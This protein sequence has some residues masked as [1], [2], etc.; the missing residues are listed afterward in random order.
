MKEG[1]VGTVD[2]TT[3]HLEVPLTL[4]TSTTVSHVSW[5]AIQISRCG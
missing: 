4:C 1:G 3:E 5:P 2:V